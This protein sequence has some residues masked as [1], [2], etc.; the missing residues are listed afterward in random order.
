MKDSRGCF[1]FNK[2]HR[3]NSHHIIY[4]VKKSVS[5]LKS[6]DPSALL[7]T[8]D[9]LFIDGMF[10]SYHIHSVYYD[11]VDHGDQ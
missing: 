4:E 11:N 7:T 1:V 9:Y 5:K 2:P 8:E 3:A 6:K 10:G